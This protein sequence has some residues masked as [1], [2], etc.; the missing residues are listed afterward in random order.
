MPYMGPGGTTAGQTGI[1][2]SSGAGF[3]PIASYLGFG[4]AIGDE[5]MAEQ[6]RDKM[7]ALTRSQAHREIGF[8]GQQKEEFQELYKRRRGFITDM[9]GNQYRSLTSR[10]QDDLYD[11]G[12][13]EESGYRQSGMAYSGTI[14]RGSDISRSRSRRDFD[15]DRDT[16]YTRLQSSLLE[17]EMA[18]KREIGAIE[19]QEA[20]AETSLAGAYSGDMGN[21]VALLQDYKSGKLSP[22]Q[23]ANILRTMG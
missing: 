13:Q 8:L 4:M 22:E 7:D 1:S 18:E 3:G 21:T 15:I 19:Q 5:I 17:S 12:R 9:Y 20:A 10:L 14:E 6:E 2:G 11:I 23:F 16:L